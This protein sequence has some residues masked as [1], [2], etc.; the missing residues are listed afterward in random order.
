MVQQ[1]LILALDVDHKLDLLVEAVPREHELARDVLD[2]LEIV[3]VLHVHHIDLL[4]HL[5]QLHLERLERH[6]LDAPQIGDL[7]VG[8]HLKLGDVGHEHVDVVHV[9]VKDLL[10]RVL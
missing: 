1:E 10:S 8:A 5:L 9:V 6:I 4:L 3:D 7:V 2:R